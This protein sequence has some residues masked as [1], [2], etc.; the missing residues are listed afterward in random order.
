M[1]VRMDRRYRQ[2]ERRYSQRYP[3]GDVK[4]QGEEMAAGMGKL[5]V[6]WPKQVTI[7]KR[8]GRKDSIW[9]WFQFQAHGHEVK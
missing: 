3:A 9:G 1:H 8:A 2:R 6:A 4:E 7:F 5:S